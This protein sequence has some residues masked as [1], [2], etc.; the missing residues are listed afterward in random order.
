ML[1]VVSLTLVRYSQPACVRGEER[2]IAM[3]PP[4]LA[5]PSCSAG[6]FYEWAMID[7]W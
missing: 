1:I 3:C 4:G 2:D 6:I 7:L 5:G